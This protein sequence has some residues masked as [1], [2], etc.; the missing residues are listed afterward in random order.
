MPDKVQLSDIVS[1]IFDVVLKRIIHTSRAIISAVFLRH[2]G[3]KIVDT[4]PTYDM[5][6]DHHEDFWSAPE[7]TNY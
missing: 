4:N 7:L 5:A 2:T 6:H 3:H 1:Y